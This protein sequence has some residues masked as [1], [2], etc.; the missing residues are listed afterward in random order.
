[1][2]I[3]NYDKLIRALGQSQFLPIDKQSLAS[4]TVGSLTSLWTAPG[5]P[6]SGATPTGPEICTK[7]LLGA[8]PFNNPAPGDLSYLGG[9]GI[10]GTISHFL[11]GYDRLIH[12]AG[13]SGVTTTAQPVGLSIPPNRNAAPDG[14]DVEWFIEIYSL[15]GT[16]AVTATVNYTDQ[17]DTAR[18][19]MVSIGGNSN[20]RQGRLTRI[21]PNPGETIKT[22]TAIT[23]ATTGT[24]GNYGVTCGK[25][26]LTESMGAPSIGVSLDFADV[27]MTQIPNDACLWLMVSSSAASSGDIRGALTIIQG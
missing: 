17:T 11:I 26:L 2:A 20:N 3:D 6:G 23:H 9:L 21:F 12:R 18:A 14:S 1:M 7:N 24:A 4:Q 13:L 5:V 8:F 27:D 25:R 10:A 16:T 22:I 19:T 15:I